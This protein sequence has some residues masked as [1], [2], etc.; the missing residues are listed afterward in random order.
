MQL[1]DQWVVLLVESNKTTS[2]A[3]SPNSSFKF[4]HCH[5][6]EPNFTQLFIHGT[7]IYLMMYQTITGQFYV[8]SNVYAI[9]YIT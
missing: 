1:M 6:V 8:K 9:V 5:H 3:F 4:N 7:T 2:V